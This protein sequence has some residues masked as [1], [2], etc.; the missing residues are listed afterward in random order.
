MAKVAAKGAEARQGVEAEQAEN[1]NFHTATIKVPEA[2]I[3]IVIG[4]KGS[5]IK[6]IQE[7]TGVTRIDTSGE[8]FTVMG[9]PT[10]VAAAEKAIK[11]LIEKGYCAMAFDDFKEEQVAVHP[12]SFPDLIGKQGAVIKAM[13]SELGVEVS[14]PE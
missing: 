7:K 3:G 11:E 12:S 9:E 10:A 5:K 2:K 13:K 6:L 8:V 4:P 1:K 14:M